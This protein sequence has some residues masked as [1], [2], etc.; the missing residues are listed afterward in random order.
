MHTEQI[1]HQGSGPAEIAAL[2]QL[3]GELGIPRRKKDD[4]DAFGN[5]L[6]IVA[7]DL[8]GPL[9]NLALLVED[10]SRGAED[11]RQP[12][13]ARKAERADQIIGRMSQMLSAVMER[14]RSGRDPLSGTMT[15]VNLV[16]VLQMVFTINQPAARRKSIAFRCLAIDPVL[17]LGD[18]ELLFEAF[19]NLIGNAL[20]HSPEGG[21]IT[22]KISAADDGSIQ[23]CIGDDGPGFGAADLLRAF[24]PLG[25]SPLA[26]SGKRGSS[27]LGL[28]ITR[29]IAERHGGRVLARNQPNGS[30]ALLT[31]RLPAAEPDSVTRKPMTSL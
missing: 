13:I 1:I 27:G 6:S 28:W 12:D 4:P 2:H 31:V 26:P 29:V 16:E 15:T 5:A 19:D 11:G 30:G 21:T 25:G 7:H 8:K 18:Q 3:N 20:K 10:I 17:V 24:R 22:C 23:V 14:A 9:S